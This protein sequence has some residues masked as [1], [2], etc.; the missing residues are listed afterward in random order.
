MDDMFDKLVLKQFEFCST[1][2]ISHRVPVGAHLPVSFRLLFRRELY[3]NL[4]PLL[5]T[6]LELVGDLLG[7]WAS[8]DSEKS[9]DWE[10]GEDDLD[11]IIGFGL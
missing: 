6:G 9:G 8:N 5:N 7:N 10:R 2:T 11:E 1:E 4:R 3:H